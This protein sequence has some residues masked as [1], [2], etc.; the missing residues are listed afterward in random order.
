MMINEKEIPLV[1]VDVYF[2]YFTL[3]FAHGRF[4]GVELAFVL[5]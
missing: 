1:S 2:I 3:I 4:P 5:F